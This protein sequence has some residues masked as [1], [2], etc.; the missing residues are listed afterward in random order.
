MNQPTL[1][2][3]PQPATIPAARG[4]LI[5]DLAQLSGTACDAEF[6]VEDMT[7]VLCA[8]L[9]RT[10][11]ATSG[12]HRLDEPSNIHHDP[13]SGPVQIAAIQG[14]GERPGLPRSALNLVGAA[15][16]LIHRCAR[17]ILDLYKSPGRSWSERDLAIAQLYVDIAA[18]YS[19]LAA[20]R[21]GRGQTR[22][23]IEQQITHD[24]LTGPSHHSLLLDRIEHAA[25][26]ASRQLTAVAVLIIDI[27]HFQEINNSVTHPAAD[28]LLVEVAHRLKG[29]LRANDSLARWAGAQFVVVCEDLTGSPAQ[30]E[31]WIHNLGRRIRL[32]LQEP[33]IH[34]HTEIIATASIG[35]VLTTPGRSPGDMIN[36]A[37]RTMLIAQQR[38]GNQIVFHKPEPTHLA[39]RRIQRGGGLSR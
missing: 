29:A 28:L 18:S 16:P 19:A 26:A 25:L 22:Q 2:R 12:L 6:T 31:R 20:A 24:D 4:T 39:R 14:R 8:V 11:G 35:A 38:G 30:I 5:D 1:P 17:D 13:V 34:R 37:I 32:T 36:H 33:P 10:F 21:D 27:D 3:E 7:R 15:P 23:G 9:G